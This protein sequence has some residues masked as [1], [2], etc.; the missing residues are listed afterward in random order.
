MLTLH[1]KYPNPPY[2]EDFDT[3]FINDLV[4]D[5]QKLNQDVLVSQEDSSLI[6]PQLLEPF[7]KPEQCDG[8]ELSIPV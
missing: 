6:D 5:N 4:S 7:K 2:G 8:M 3:M 1:Y